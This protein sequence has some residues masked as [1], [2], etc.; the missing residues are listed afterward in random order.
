MRTSP[1]AFALIRRRGPG[2]SD[3]WLT[4]WNDGWNALNLVGGHKRD[5]ESF[6]DCCG[7][8]VAEELGVVAGV[9]FRVAP[10]SECRLDYIADSRRTGE[11]TAYTHEA[12]VVD[13]L[14]D[15]ARDRIAADSTCCWL[16]EREVR[17]LRAAD[18]RAVS[19]TVEHILIQ[20]HALSK[21]ERYDLF[22]SYAHDDDADG[23]VAALADALQQQ[24]QEFTN[25]KLR[26]FF[27]RHAICTAD[28]WKYR[29][30]GGLKAARALL[31]VLS[32]TYFVRPWCLRELETF[33]ELEKARAWPG[34]A[35]TPVYAVTV[36]DADPTRTAD[37]EAWL[38]SILQKQYCDLV[39][40]R[41]HGVAAFRNDE[42][43]ARLKALNARVV[44]RVGRVERVI[45][46]PSHGPR[47]NPN[48]VGREDEL[49]QV[50]EALMHQQV[51]AVTAVHGIGGAGKSALA[52][53]YGHVFGDEYPGGRFW[54]PAEHHAD[55]RDLLRLLEAPLG[56]T[57]TDEERKD[58]DIGYRRVRAELERRPRTLL[59]LDNVNKTEPLSPAH[60]GAFRPDA[61]RVHILV[62]MREEPPADP[63]GAVGRIALD[64]LGPDDGR[65]LLQRYRDFGADEDEWHAA[66]RIV[67]V[68]DGHAL[69]LEV[70]GVYVWQRNRTEPTF[71]YEMYLQWMEKKGLLT[72]LEGAGKSAKVHL[73]LKED[74]EKLVSALLE[75]MLAGL[76]EPERRAL[77]YASLLAPDW[78]VL[79]WLKELV[80]A[81]FP[82]AVARA[83]EWD[84]DPWLE[85]VARLRGLR[86]LGTTED[87]RI[88]RMHR[89]VH[90]VV[91]GRIGEAMDALRER[92]VK[93]TMERANLLWDGWVDRAAR[94]EIDPLRHFS[95]E[96]IEKEPVTGA[97]LANWIYQPLFL[98]GR[99]LEAKL[100][101][102]KA[103]AIE[104]K[105]FDAEHPNLGPSYSNLVRP[106][107]AIL[108]EIV[109]GS[110]VF[111]VG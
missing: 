1:G 53:E 86:L 81:D 43:R 12:F 79:P 48:F 85:I 93:Y 27:D 6:R 10:E 18:G 46:S 11:K 104:E 2:G 13:L 4:N 35:L 7:R 5:R 80:G 17:A 63:G 39:A 89:V 24:H 111:P 68:I 57:F 32:P 22:L 52:A 25:E 67:S 64:R 50:R 60:L 40:W 73:S 15:A 20:T 56:L 76:S 38:R 62:T 54:L 97:N 78:V 28:D 98:L 102:R 33:V 16:S 84:A 105:H 59:V 71:G 88:M 66:R 34:E 44:E 103:I 107:N 26:I 21:E 101:L 108:A 92:L 41:P 110:L 3:E 9:D 14:T 51:A 74:P 31:S 19:V 45:R 82:A 91:G 55:L 90:A 47:H 96:L 87:E 100:L 77:E 29:I 30:L 61:E 72:A 83:E 94:W 95:T 106:E 36:P 70:I 69:S 8:E 58:R 65:R 37:G 49:R 42:V 99:L 75:P 109:A 23:F